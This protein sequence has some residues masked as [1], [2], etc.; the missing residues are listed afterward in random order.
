MFETLKRLFKK[1]DEVTETETEN[2]AEQQECE[3]MKNYLKEKA[4]CKELHIPLVTNARDEHGKLTG[5]KFSDDKHTS[6]IRGS[7]D[8]LEYISNVMYQHKCHLQGQRFW[9]DF[10]KQHQPEINDIYNTLISILNKKFENTDYELAMYVSNDKN[11]VCS[12]DEAY[13][14]IRLIV[15]FDEWSEACLKTLKE[16]KNQDKLPPYFQS[17]T[18]MVF[19]KRTPVENPGDP[20]VIDVSN[21]KE[22]G[23]NFKLTKFV[24]NR[25]HYKDLETFILGKE[26]KNYGKIVKVYATFKIEWWYVCFWCQKEVEEETKQ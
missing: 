18:L 16:C 1:K 13:D 7:A 23:K 14:L 3:A 12:I 20:T 4:E 8:F 9:R 10:N 11:V 19:K 22:D 25:A 2:S 5:L 24:V 15:T 21:V 6:F 26:F 17:A